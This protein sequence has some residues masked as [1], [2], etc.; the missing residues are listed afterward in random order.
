VPI[1]ESLRVI[2][3]AY[4]RDQVELEFSLAEKSEIAVLARDN[5]QVMLEGMGGNH[6]S[7]AVFD[8]IKRLIPHVPGPDELNLWNL[9]GPPTTIG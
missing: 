2:A 8:F 1:T 7:D 5:I 6:S 4:R 3:T 9:T